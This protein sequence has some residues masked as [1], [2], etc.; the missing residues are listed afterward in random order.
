MFGTSVVD[1]PTDELHIE[2]AETIQFAP[3]Q[4]IITPNPTC[5]THILSFSP[6]N[7]S[8]KSLFK[9]F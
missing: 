2:Q 9:W 8:A 5:I 3:A 6:Q 7:Q 1:L 4:S